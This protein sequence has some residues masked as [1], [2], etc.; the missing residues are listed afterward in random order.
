ML[1]KRIKSR[2]RDEEKGIQSSF[3]RG[4]NGYY[5]TF[6]DVLKQKYGIDTLTVDVTNLD[7]RTGQGQAN[8][9]DSVSDFFAQ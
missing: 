4:L 6:P 8:F 1:L 9:L 2:G 7:I 5:G 3:L